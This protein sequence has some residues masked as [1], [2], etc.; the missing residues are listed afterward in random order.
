M[1]NTPLPQKINHFYGRFARLERA[2]LR[3]KLLQL[4]SLILWGR[5]I[6]YASWWVHAARSSSVMLFKDGKLLL[7][8]RAN[9]LNGN[10]KYGIIGGFVDDF[11]SF[12]ET[13]SREIREETGLII[14]PAAFTTA[15]LF[16]ID[17]RRST[18]T[19]QDDMPNV[20]A[21]YGYHIS[22]DELKTLTTTNEFSEFIW[23]DEAALD[24]LHT[25]GE[26]AF[27]H[28]YKV[29]KQAY[30]EGWHE[31]I[32]LGRRIYERYPHD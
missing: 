14:P 32:P 18:I 2:S 12:A 4:L 20:S 31:F 8:R 10:L 9:S 11:E 17:Q 27:E 30:A 22:D 6:A 26:L 28:T 25:N 13:T 7:G 1:H 21:I 16:C 15:N 3:F 23:A 24:A 19:E 5:K 29:L